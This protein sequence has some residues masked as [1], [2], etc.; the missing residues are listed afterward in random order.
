MT[1]ALPAP[2]LLI[3]TDRLSSPRNLSHTIPDLLEAGCRWIMVREKDL[4]T[5]TLG[6]LAQEIVDLA[7]PYEACVVVNGDVAAA[8]FSGADGVHLQT[9]K[10]VQ[11]ARD[12]LAEGALIGV[13]THSL[14]DAR[15]AAVAGADYI[16]LSPVFLTDSKPGYGPALGVDLLGRVCGEFPVPVIALA[17]I[18]PETAASCM[19]TGAAGIAVMGTVMRSEGPGEVVR[20]YLRSLGHHDQVPEM[21]NR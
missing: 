21:C 5:A 14:E 10:Q 6:A 8:Q 19:D 15:D 17:G 16:T 11:P 18:T 13:S 7:R 1:S 3:I 9:A 4:D 12:R 20:D 2:P